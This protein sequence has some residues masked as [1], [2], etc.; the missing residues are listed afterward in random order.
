MLPQTKFLSLAYAVVCN[1]L[2]PYVFDIKG[3]KSEMWAPPCQENTYRQ[4]LWQLIKAAPATWDQLIH[5]GI[6]KQ[7]IISKNTSLYAAID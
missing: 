2:C 6:C 1:N 7:H 5:N 4:L 3:P